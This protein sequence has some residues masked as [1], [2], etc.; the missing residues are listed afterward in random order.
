M[1]WLIK[2]DVF[3]L[4][5]VDNEN[6]CCYFCCVIYKR[7]NVFYKFGKKKYMIIRS[8]VIYVVIY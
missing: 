8:D 3:K 4:I 1:K 7:L 5:F 2:F 6:K